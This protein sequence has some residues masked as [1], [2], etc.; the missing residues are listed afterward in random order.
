MK[1][2]PLEPI[3]TSIYVSDEQTPADL[4][5]VIKLE[6]DNGIYFGEVIAIETGDAG[7]ALIFR[8]IKPKPEFDS[9][10]CFKIKR[11]FSE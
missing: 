5:D 6:H 3:K 4:G 9:A 10:P 1:N 7:E 2:E 8:Y 11:P